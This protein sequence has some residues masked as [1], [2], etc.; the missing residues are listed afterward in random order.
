MALDP[1]ARQANV[2]DSIKKFLADSLETTESIALTFDVSLSAPTLQGTS[3]DRWIAVGIGPLDMQTLS[4]FTVNLFCCTRR[5][6]EGF[7]LAQLRDTVYNYLIDTDQTDGMKKITFY[8]SRA[9]GAWT[10]LESG[11]VVSEVIESGVM[12]APDETKYKILTVTM[13]FASKV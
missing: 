5:D 3:V 12:E 4:A 2:M 11:I 9:A 1:T 6:P 13:K 7:K 8:R 10:D